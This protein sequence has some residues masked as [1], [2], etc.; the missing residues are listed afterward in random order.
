MNLC[1]SFHLAIVKY[2]ISPT[3]TVIPI[4]KGIIAKPN[5]LSP[6]SICCS[7]F[8]SLSLKS[9][10]F[11]NCSS[12]CGQIS[13]SLSEGVCRINLDSNSEIPLSTPSICQNSLELHEVKPIA[14]NF[15]CFV[16]IMQKLEI[17]LCWMNVSFAFFNIYF[18]TK[19]KRFQILQIPSYKTLSR[20][21]QSVQKLRSDTTSWY[22]LQTL[23]VKVTRS[24]QRVSGKGSST[25]SPTK[26]TE[27]LLS[28]HTEE[29]RGVPAN[30]ETL[31]R[32]LQRLTDHWRWHWEVFSKHLR[33]EIFPD[34]SKSYS[35]FFHSF[36]QVH[37]R[38]FRTRRTL[39]FPRRG[40]SQNVS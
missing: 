29:Q 39:R 30:N 17:L 16:F 21:F 14:K 23:R 19:E 9:F 28:M 22:S 6:P 32:H 20:R 33:L 7:I 2:I 5:I 12:N 8:Y 24:L 38:R 31:F 13:S 18:F 26:I 36:L 34:F 37:E 3:T 25:R 4:I 10:L 35:S 27:S 1:L 15:S 40:R 11:F